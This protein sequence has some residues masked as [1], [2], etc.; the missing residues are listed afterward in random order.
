M[1][2]I[3]FHIST[4]LGKGEFSEAMRIGKGAPS[5][6]TTYVSDESCKKAGLNVPSNML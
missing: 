4:A 1:L 6:P 5:L 2:Q 3:R